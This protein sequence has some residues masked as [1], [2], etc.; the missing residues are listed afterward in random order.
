MKILLADGPRHGDTLNAEGDPTAVIYV[1]EFAFTTKAPD[2]YDGGDR[3]AWMPKH[4][5]N[6][7]AETRSGTRIYEWAGR[8]G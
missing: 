1:A 2:D 3:L 8:I 6:L 4:M 7:R 5:Y